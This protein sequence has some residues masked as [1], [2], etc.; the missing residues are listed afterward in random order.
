MDDNERKRVQG[1]HRQAIV[2]VVAIVLVSFFVSGRVALLLFLLFVAEY[3]FRL[4][5]A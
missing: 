4:Y 3:A 1:V 2:A 5:R